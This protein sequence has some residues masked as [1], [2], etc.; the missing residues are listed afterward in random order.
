MVTIYT[1]AGISFVGLLI[2]SLS[3]QATLTHFFEM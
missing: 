1:Y 2:V 3:N